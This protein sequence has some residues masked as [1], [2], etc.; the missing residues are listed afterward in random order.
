MPQDLGKHRDGFLKAH[1]D[2]CYYFEDSKVAI[3]AVGEV[4]KFTAV[5]LPHYE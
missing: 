1:N 4:Y 3:A 5:L 2:L